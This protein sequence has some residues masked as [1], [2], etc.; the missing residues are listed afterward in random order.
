MFGQS[1]GCQAK[2]DLFYAV[3]PT[4]MSPIASIIIVIVIDI[5]IRHHIIVID[6]VIVIDIDTVTT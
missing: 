2:Y 1:F 5:M 3:I 4:H 6:I